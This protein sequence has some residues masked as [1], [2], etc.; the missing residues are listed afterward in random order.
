MQVYTQLAFEFPP[1]Q[2]R[3]ERVA[4]SA[5]FRKRFLT[6]YDYVCA[7]CGEEARTIDHFVPVVLGGTND[8]ANLY[9]CCILCNSTA[10]A[11]VF[12]TF[13]E[14]QRYVLLRRMFLGSLREPVHGEAVARG[15]YAS[16]I[17]CG[18]YYRF[19]SNATIFLCPVCKYMD[20]HHPLPAW[21]RSRIDGFLSREFPTLSSRL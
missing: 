11:K 21:R 1:A 19:A 14:K 2:I 5:T 8:I 3:F 4:F 18:G 20:E 10:Q 13:A 16:C 6:I 15:D 17:D 7:Y 12:P 9:P